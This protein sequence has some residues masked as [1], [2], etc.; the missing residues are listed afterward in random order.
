MRDGD[1]NKTIAGLFP[2]IRSV[3]IHMTWLVTVPHSIYMF[4]R[5]SDPDSLGLSM[6][7][8]FDT[9][10]SPLHE[11]VITIQVTDP[12]VAELCPSFSMFLIPERST[13]LIHNPAVVKKS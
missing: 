3:M 6:W 12:Y 10:P 2:I 13:L 1:G 7:T 9:R 4:I 5:G 8:P 11:I